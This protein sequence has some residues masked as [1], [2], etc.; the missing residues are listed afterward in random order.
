MTLPLAGGLVLLW[1][2]LEP[3]E[4][5]SAARGPEDAD[6][7]NGDAETAI[8]GDDYGPENPLIPS[9]PTQD[10]RQPP[11]SGR[12]SA[13]NADQRKED[14]EDS[15]LKAQWVMARSAKVVAVVSIIQ[16]VVGGVGLVAL[17]VTLRYNREAVGHAKASA[18]AA[19]DAA[20]EARRSAD[21]AEQSVI[22]TDRP[23]ISIDMTIA[24]PLK[25]PVEDERDITL[26]VDCTWK[27]I[28]KSPA[29]NVR[30]N[31][32][33]TG[34]YSDTDAKISDAIENAGRPYLVAMVLG[35]QPL[36]P[37]EG[38]EFTD[39]LKLPLASFKS[40]MEQ[41]NQSCEEEDRIVRQKIIVTAQANY[42]IA[43]D[44]KHGRRHTIAAW[45]I[46]PL[47]NESGFTA[48]PGEHKIENLAV[49]R[50]MMGSSLS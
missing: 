19:R 12:D 5:Y 27:N 10:K 23:W 42:T 43:S 44:P 24:S 41:W 45:A 9:R 22:A 7:K 28:G 48:A 36:F 2:W 18:I 34:G 26:K 4:I 1:A 47:S 17:F 6:K 29:A 20:K 46:Y 40:A 16:I 35:G 49:H 14:R 11:E 50:L 38:L 15:D 37:G 8:S 31:I 33:M 3:E 39:I 25:F 13:A 30:V 32:G 21:V